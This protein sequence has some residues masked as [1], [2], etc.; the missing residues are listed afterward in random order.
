MK[1]YLID[2]QT[3]S[4]HV[5][6]VASVS[7]ASHLVAEDCSSLVEAFSFKN[8]DTVFHDLRGFERHRATI[9]N[10]PMSEKSMGIIN[11]DTFHDWVLPFFGR[12]LILGV[13][14]K[15]IRCNLESNCDVRSTEEEIMFWTRFLNYEDGVDWITYNVYQEFC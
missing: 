11:S 6:E 5:I 2:A 15:S 4:I 8:G 3:R 12:V 9:Q 7:S 13:S 1:G 14:Y 10:I